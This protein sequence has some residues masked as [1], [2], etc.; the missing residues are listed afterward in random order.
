MAEP[1]Y[2][3]REEFLNLLLTKKIESNERKFKKAQ[4]ELLN[5]KNGCFKKTKSKEIHLK[6]LLQQ[7]KLQEDA[8]DKL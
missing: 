2:R 1:E 7:N 6:D 4:Q 3:T 5:L 8:I